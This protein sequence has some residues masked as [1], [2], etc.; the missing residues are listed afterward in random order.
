MS[1]LV[2]VAIPE[3]D[4]YVWQVSSEK[5]PHI[6]LLFLG[7]ADTNQDSEE[8]VKF[9]EHAATVMSPFYMDA[10][11]RGTLGEDDADVIFF[12]K[13]WDYKAVVAFRDQL[14]TNI[15]IN[16]AYNSTEQFP[17]WTP[18]LT[19]GYPETPAKTPERERRI[20]SVSFDRIAVWFGDYEGPEFR[21]ER[22]VYDMAEVG[23]SSMSAAEAKELFHYGK[24][25]MKWGKRM[26]DAKANAA[27]RQATALAPK[28][29]VVSTSNAKGKAQIKTKKGQN[30]PAHPD[31]ITAKVHAQ[32][33]RKSGTNSMSNKELQELA[34]R[35]DLEQ[36]VERLSPAKVS[37]GRKTTRYILANPKMSSEIAQEGHT[38][39]KTAM[40]MA[41]AR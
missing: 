34:S 13:G 12:E 22:K 2:I 31:A 14:L 9:V 38:I 18:H 26:S 8:I 35:I 23:M 7:D 4:D 29:V 30:Q 37:V 6:T 11:Y 19:L 15:H 27:V 21:L 25:G 41:K 1:K 10:D 24:K 40:K 32:K 3:Q 16:K 33:R 17:E 5:V 20:Y 39:V 36:R 28:E